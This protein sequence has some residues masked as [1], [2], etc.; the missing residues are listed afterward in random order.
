MADTNTAPEDLGAPQ[1]FLVLTDGTPVYDR[2][3]EPA[4]KVAHV[5]ADDKDEI[6]QGLVLDTGDG[7]RYAAAAQVDGI[8]ERAVIIGPPAKD[9]PE[10]SEKADSSLGDG[11]RRAWEWLV[12]P[13]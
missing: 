4:G 7:H 2:S 13:K 10:P 9:L 1:S 5:L 3:G 11:L 6:F 12:R 8:Y